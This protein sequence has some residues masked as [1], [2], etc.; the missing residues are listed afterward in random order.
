MGWGEASWARPAQFRDQ[1]VTAQTVL[2]GPS[3][4]W[5][6]RPLLISPKSGVPSFLMPKPVRSPGGLSFRLLPEVLTEAWR[7]HV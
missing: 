7:R 5:R 2:L 3:D 4:A 6:T 1:N